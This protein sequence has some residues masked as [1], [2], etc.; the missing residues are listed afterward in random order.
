M[1]VSVATC[2]RVGHGREDAEDV[3]VRGL[4]YL[5]GPCGASTAVQRA[6]ARRTC[7]IRFDILHQHVGAE[8]IETTYSYL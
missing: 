4:R 8:P 3:Y 2:E 5:L 7:T 1:N 6:A